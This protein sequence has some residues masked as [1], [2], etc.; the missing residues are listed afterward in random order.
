M[1]VKIILSPLFILLLFLIIF[2]CIS[3]YHWKK[4]SKLSHYL[5]V[6]LAVL[7]L[8][9]FL[10]SMP[11]ISLRLAGFLESPYTEINDYDVQVVTVLSG[12]LLRGPEQEM[13]M[14]SESTQSRVVRGV[15]Y[16]KESEAEYLILQGRS[17]V[18]HPEHM[19]DLMKELAVDMGLSEDDIITEPYSN[20]TYEHPLQL[21]KIEEI[22]GIEKVA[23]VTSAWH[24]K[25][26]E[27]EFDKYFD[28]VIAVPAE[29][30]SFTYER[31][32]RKLLPR[33]SAL[34]ESTKVI[35]EFIGRQWYRVK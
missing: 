7:T 10:L 32:L 18:T 2:V 22:M 21:L 33:L 9:V 1:M 27:R 11:V 30:Y 26:A 29:F 34:E 28:S 17:S 24:L 3:L 15:R 14:M 8:S 5:T 31:G 25:R 12:G 20:N 13:D 6:C 35:H 4:S 19:T 16:F 23:V